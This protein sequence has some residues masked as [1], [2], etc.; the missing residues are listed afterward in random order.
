M[1]TGPITGTLSLLSCLNHLNNASL[2]S[3]LSGF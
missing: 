1:N 2:T 3:R